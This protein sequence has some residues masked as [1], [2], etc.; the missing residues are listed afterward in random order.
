MIG[1]WHQGFHTPEYMPRSRGF[2]SFY[3]IMTSSTDHYN[4]EVG[5]DG[6]VGDCKYNNNELIDMIDEDRPA[7]GVED[8]SKFGDDRYSERAVEL[9]SKHDKQT[10]M[11]M[12]LSL[13]MPHY[14]YQVPE[15]FAK[16]HNKPTP[17]E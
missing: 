16:L 6:G 17:E 8:G 1:K 10:P 4:Q 15:E 2:D 14:P 11:F 9:I 7:Y 12:Y 5:H 3:G 13:Q